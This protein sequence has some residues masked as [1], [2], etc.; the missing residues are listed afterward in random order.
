MI[1][2]A[3]YIRI[4]QYKNWTFYE[5]LIQEYE[6]FI[7]QKLTRI[8]GV[9]KIKTSFILSTVKYETMIHVD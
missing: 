1:D 9:Q 8:K 3:K 7:L 5:L 6:N 4:L 2:N